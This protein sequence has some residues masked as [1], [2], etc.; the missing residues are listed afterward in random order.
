V[1]RIPLSRH[2]EEPK[3]DRM[4]TDSEPR[5]LKIEPDGERLGTEWGLGPFTIEQTTEDDGDPPLGREQGLRGRSATSPAETGPG[6]EWRSAGRPAPRSVTGAGGA[7][8]T[9][10]NPGTS[11]GGALGANGGRRESSDGERTGPERPRNRGDPRRGA[12]AGWPKA[13]SA[14][15]L[16][17]QCERRRREVSTGTKLKIRRPDGVRARAL[18]RRRAATLP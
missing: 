4:G 5:S 15:D 18:A 8:R 16:R 13:S 17:T 1:A 12:C 14:R 6:T 7:I 3:R 10:P 2:G 11:G 9:A